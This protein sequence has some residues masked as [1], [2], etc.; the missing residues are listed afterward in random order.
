ME[1]TVKEFHLSF[2][3]IVL[4]INICFTFILMKEL[5]AGSA[6]HYGYLSSLTPGFSI[7]SFVYIRKFKHDTLLIRILQ[8]LN[9]LFIVIPIVVIIYLASLIT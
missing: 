6:L 9:L 8:G 2:P 7:A 5:S 4:L 1:K 3:I